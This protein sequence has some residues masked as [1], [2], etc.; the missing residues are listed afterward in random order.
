M[1]ISVVVN[2]YVLGAKVKITPTHKITLQERIDPRHTRII[3]SDVSQR[4]REFIEKV[5]A[6]KTTVID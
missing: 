6:Y 5:L 2:N 4:E 1:N 3:Y